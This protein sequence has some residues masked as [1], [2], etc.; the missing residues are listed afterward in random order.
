MEYDLTETERDLYNELAG[1]YEY[2]AGIPRT[3]AE[4]KAMAEILHRRGYNKAIHSGIEGRRE[5]SREKT[6]E[7][8]GIPPEGPPQAQETRLEREGRAAL[9][10]MAARNIPLIGAYASGAMIDKQEPE[11]FTTDTAEIASLIE[12]NGNRQ[13]K[14]KGTSIQRFYFI[15]QTAGLLCL[16]I[17]R[18]PGK[19]DGLKELYKLFPRDTLPRALQD[20]EQFFP[21]YVKTPSSGYH[22]YFRYSGDTVRKTDL[23]PEVEIKHGKPGLTAPGSRKENGAYVLY[24]DIEK[25]PPLYGIIIDRIDELQKQK[26]EKTDTQ[27]TAAS[28]PVSPSRRPAPGNWPD[29]P[30]ITLDTLADEAAAAYSGN[31]DRQVC[32]AGKASRC[33]FSVTDTINYATS[34]PAIFGSGADTENTIKSVFRDNGGM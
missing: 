12:G 33:K 6:I 11:N 15:P 7:T 8:H 25:A 28:R 20:I 13:G 2:D 16:D 21:C 34:N 31:H 23:C 17:D 22:L 29:K 18:K 1:K 19:S 27:R 32:F 10:Y 26:Q 14:G 5:P 3:E 9:E 24:G 4:S 30:R